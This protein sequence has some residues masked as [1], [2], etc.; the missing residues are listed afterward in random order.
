MESRDEKGW[1]VNTRETNRITPK[2]RA[3]GSSPS[4]P[5]KKDASFVY[6]DKR[7]FFLLS[8]AKYRMNMEKAGFGAVEWLLQSLL[9]AFDGRRMSKSSLHKLNFFDLQTT[10]KCV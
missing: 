8:E 2:P 7:G 9:L 5:A 10:T 3:E 4:A 6:Q 1:R